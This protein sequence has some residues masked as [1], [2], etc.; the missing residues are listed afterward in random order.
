MKF[1]KKG[2][3]PNKSKLFSASF[4]GTCSHCGTHIEEGDSIGYL[5]D[6]IVC[7]VCHTEDV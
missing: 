1:G 7:D 5:D 2:V 6:E 4:P 3:E